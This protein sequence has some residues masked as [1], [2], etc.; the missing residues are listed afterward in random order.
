MINERCRGAAIVEIQCRL[1]EHFS[2]RE[3]VVAIYLFGSQARGQADHLSDM[4]IALLLRPDLPRET[5]W[6]LGLRLDVEVCDILGTDNV[7]VIILNTAPLEAQ[8][9]IIRT[10]VLL[11]CND[12]NVRTDYEV[13]MMNAYWDSK[14]MWEEY[15][16]YA[17]Q[18]IR[19]KMTDAERQQYQDT[20]AKIRRMHRASES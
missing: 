14:R 2:G 15:D 4:D 10:A 11:H 12:E 3:E 6:R 13:W 18:R 8:F 20:I 17:L 5:M 1:S 7:D 9:E 16:A 19:E